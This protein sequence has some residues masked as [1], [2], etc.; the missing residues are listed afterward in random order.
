MI[1]LDILAAVVETAVDWWLDRRDEKSGAK[2][3]E[4]NEKKDEGNSEN[5]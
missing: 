4:K 5:R 3:D 1:V 2:K